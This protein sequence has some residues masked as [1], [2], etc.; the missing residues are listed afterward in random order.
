MDWPGTVSLSAGLAVLL[1]T[2]AS[3]TSWG[4]ASGRTAGALTASAVLLGAW[5]AV[6]LRV[7]DPL[8]DLRAMS[9]R[10]IAPLYL[11]SLPI[12]IAFFGAATATTTFVAASDRASGY[13]FG[14]DIT[15]L[16]YLG[17][18]SASASVLG[19]MVVPR[20]V[21][22]AS[23]RAAVCTGCAAML[24]GYAGLAVWH[25]ALWQAV[26][27]NAVSNLGIGLVASAMAMVRTERADT[28][29]TG[30]DV[31]HR[32][33]HRRQHG[34]RGIRGAAD[35]GHHRRH[36]RAARVGVRGGMAHLRPGVTALIAHRRGDQ[37]EG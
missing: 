13:G 34:R 31:H 12:G 26:A 4:W 6:E 17:L 3:G 11:A 28:A 32:T 24:A 8:T 14:L 36:Q 33:R 2:L 7:T 5:V 27:A 35:P 21:K 16:A 15:A 23:H 20:L 9:R 29:S 1:L 25:G 37:A 10:A 19:A 18:V 30:R 22:R